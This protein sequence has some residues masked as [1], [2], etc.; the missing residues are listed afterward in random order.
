MS[1]PRF[2]FDEED[3]KD[4]LISP[5]EIELAEAEKVYK[6]FGLEG[7]QEQYWA[8]I[9]KIALL[10]FPELQEGERIGFIEIRRRLTQIRMAGYPTKLYS[11]MNIKEIS[12]YFFI[13]VRPDIYKNAGDHCPNVLKNIKRENE[14]R[15]LEARL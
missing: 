5:E 2:E 11:H 1:E 4:L 12:D 7:R 8:N 15:K 6:K 10:R 9:A 3:L 14:R 13:E